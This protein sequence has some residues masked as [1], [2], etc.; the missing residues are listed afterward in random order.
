MVSPAL[1]VI[2]IV[3]SCTIQR[4]VYEVDEDAGGEDDNDATS[5]MASMT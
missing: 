2:E 1:R 3:K 4:D 5:I